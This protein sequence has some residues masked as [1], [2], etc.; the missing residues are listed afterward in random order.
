MVFAEGE[1][2]VSCCAQKGAIDVRFGSLADI[3]TCLVDVRFTPESRNAGNGNVL[4]G[5]SRT[6][7]AMANSRVISSD[8]VSAFL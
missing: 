8:A 4:F 2:V 6:I 3:A 5:T 1:Q 7:D